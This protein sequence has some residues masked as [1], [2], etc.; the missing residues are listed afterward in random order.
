VTLTL[1][2]I[3]VFSVTKIVMKVLEKNKNSEKP[4]YDP[5]GNNLV[6]HRA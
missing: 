2:F 4:N 6:F 5:F 1:T 3:I